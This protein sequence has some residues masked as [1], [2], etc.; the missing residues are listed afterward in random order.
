[1]QENVFHV[2]RELQRLP[3]AELEELDGLC[4]H[5]TFPMNPMFKGVWNLRLEAE[6]LPVRGT[7]DQ[8]LPL[9]QALGARRPC[10]GIQE[11]FATKRVTDD[12]SYQEVSMLGGITLGGALVIA[13]IVILLVWSFWLGLILILVGLI[14]FGGFARGKWY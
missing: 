11:C 12:S 8:P 14:A 7:V 13:G 5:H 10:G 6:A 1:M 9:G 2:F 3:G 4:R